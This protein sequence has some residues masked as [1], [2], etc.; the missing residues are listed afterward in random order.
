MANRGGRFGVY[1]R[2]INRS[3]FVTILRRV[4]ENRTHAALCRMSS[5]LSGFNV[6][7]HEHIDKCIGLNVIYTV[8]VILLR[9]TAVYLCSCA[10]RN[11]RAGPGENVTV[12]YF[13]ITR[14]V[15]E[16]RNLT[17]VLLETNNVTRFPITPLTL[18]HPSTTYVPGR[19]D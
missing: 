4:D 16:Q 6:T 11:R 10:R 19:I 7:A 18:F 2:P 14:I 8:R 1:T 9:W 17:V 3:Y 12:R 15:N 13:H 5:V